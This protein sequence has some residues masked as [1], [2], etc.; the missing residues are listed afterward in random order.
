MFKK[1]RS[2]CYSPTYPYAKIIITKSQQEF[3]TMLVLWQT[4]L[5]DLG[6]YTHSPSWEEPAVTCSEPWRSACSAPGS[7][8]AFFAHSRTTNNGPN[9]A[10]HHVMIMV[11]V[12]VAPLHMWQHIVT[13]K[14]LQDSGWMYFPKWRLYTHVIPQHEHTHGSEAGQCNIPL[15]AP[16]GAGVVSAAEPLLVPVR[17]PHHWMLLQ[18]GRAPH[19]HPAPRSKQRVVEDTRSGKQTHL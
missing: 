13:Y 14:S 2:K 6:K 10:E 19:P 3:F 15:R 12:R 17:R 9:L 11:S 1:E 7:Y 4:D 8:G 5:K 18:P 16:A